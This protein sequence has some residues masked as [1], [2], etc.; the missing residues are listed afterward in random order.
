[1][2]WRCK[3]GGSIAPRIL[4]LASTSWWVVSFR[5]YFWQIW[6]KIEIARKLL[7]QPP[8]AKFRV[9]PFSSFEGIICWQTDGQTRPPL[10]A[11]SLRILCKEF[12]EK[13]GFVRRDNSNSYRKENVF[14]SVLPQTQRQEEDR[15]SDETSRG[16]LRWNELI[17]T[18][19]VLLLLLL[20][21][22]W[23]FTHRVN[24]W[25]PISS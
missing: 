9:N 5:G 13:C 12:A 8:N 22:S 1:M 20:W 4:D 24:H 23:N 25:Q 19:S 2:P 14:N 6:T 15:R 3:A 11:F 10:Y 21:C 7:L 18:Q 16:V 17:M